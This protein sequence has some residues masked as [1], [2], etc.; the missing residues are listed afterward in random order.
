MAKKNVTNLNELFAYLNN[1]LKNT[2]Q[3]RDGEVI[4]ETID[5]AKNRVDE[6]VYAVYDPRIYQRTGQ[7]R[8]EW[9]VINTANGV[10]IFNS[11]RDGNTYVAEVVETGQGYSYSF[12]Y[13]G[14]PR[15][16]TANTREELIKSGKLNEALKKD[17]RKLRFKVI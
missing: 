13:D 11:R 12:P 10:A 5:T 9:E 3:N 8:E 15:P 6:D 4:K 17:L 7:L 16:F 14:V 1:Q 2:V